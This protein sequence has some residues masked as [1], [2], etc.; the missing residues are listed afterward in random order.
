MICQY[1]IHQNV[2]KRRGDRQIKAQ[3]TLTPTES[4]RLIAKAIAI[5]P[6]IKKAL[7]KGTIA[8]TTSTTVGYVFEEITGEKIED[9]LSFACGI[10]VP[11]GMCL[12]DPETFY[13][14]VMIQNGEVVKIDR[15]KTHVKYREMW[16]EREWG[17]ND[18]FIKGANAIDPFGKV[19]VLMGSTVRAE[20]GHIAKMAQTK[21]VKVIIPVGLEKLIPVSIEKAVEA[22]GGEPSSVNETA[23]SMGI[24]VWLLPMA[25]EVVTEVEA[26]RLLSGA[27]A[28][29]IGAGGI[30]GAEGSITLILRGEE[31]AVN[32]AIKIIEGIKGGKPTKAYPSK[33]PCTHF[34][35]TNICSYR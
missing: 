19:A 35:K 21:G 22:A 15:R 11:K 13:P 31:N 24:K 33:C 18:V 28:I 2:G 26:I 20:A 7:G 32:K 10:T 16:S 25:G 8:L 34:A 17:P 5:H 30:G 27:E 1:S 14:N 6:L 12:T 29:P 3:V 4:K 23:Y 9:G